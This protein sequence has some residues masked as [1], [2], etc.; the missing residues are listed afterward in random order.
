M[1]LADIA[2]VYNRLP[3]ALHW[4]SNGLVNAAD[5]HGQS[6]NDESQ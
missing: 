6:D 2:A 1:P 5:H 4:G 3:V